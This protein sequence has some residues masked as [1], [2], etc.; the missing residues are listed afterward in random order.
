VE[1]EILEKPTVYDL[2]AFAQNEIRLGESVRAIGGLRL[3]FH[4]TDRSD[5]ELALNPKIGLVLSPSSETGIRLSASRGYRAPSATE[6]FVSA[7]QMG[8]QVVPNPGLK[9]ESAWSV[10]VGAWGRVSAWAHLEGSL[11]QTDFHDLIEVAAALG[12]AFGTFQFRNVA[13]ARIRGLDVSA[14]LGWLDGLLQGRVGYVLLATRNE[15]TGKALTYRSK[16][17]LTAS[18]DYGPVGIDLRYRSRVEEVVAYPLDPRD[19]ITLVD[20]RAGFRWA[21]LEG[22][23]K[24]GNLFQATYVDVQ[25]RHLGPSRSV[26]LMVQS[27]F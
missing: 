10:E 21:G 2:A 25:E 16:H 22:Q 27:T 1:S 5:S 14:R 7:T 8:F 17:N 19:S 3:D 13:E 9:G 11:F 24:V 12:G 26:Q 15:Q 18:A 23:I 6:R 4:D 20:L